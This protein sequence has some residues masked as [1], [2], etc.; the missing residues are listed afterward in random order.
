MDGEIQGLTEHSRPKPV[1][2][3]KWERPFA[4]NA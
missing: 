3:N 1:T 2:G 4:A